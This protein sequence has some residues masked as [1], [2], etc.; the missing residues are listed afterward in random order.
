[1]LDVA[2]LLSII[3]WGT[4]LTVGIVFV[5]KYE[6]EYQSFCI[7]VYERFRGRQV[8]LYFSWVFALSWPIILSITPRVPITNPEMLFL[9]T[10]LPKVYFFAVAL[11]YYLCGGFIFSLS[12]LLLVWKALRPSLPPE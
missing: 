9:M 1:M 12:I 8:F 2:L 7:R 6:G 3:V 4:W 11:S 5:K 10:H